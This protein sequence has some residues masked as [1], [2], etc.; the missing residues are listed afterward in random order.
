MSMLKVI[1]VLAESNKSWE[2]AAQNAI[3]TAG[4]SVRNIKSI[5]IKNHE[6]Q[7]ENGKIKKYRINGKISFLLD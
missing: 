2:D 1:E 5:Y 7:V 6:A 3:D 4:K